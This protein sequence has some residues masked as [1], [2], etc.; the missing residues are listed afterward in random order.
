MK[1]Q[2][3]SSKAIDTRILAIHALDKLIDYIR[4][5]DPELSIGQAT[6]LAAITLHTLPEL[7]QENPL[8]V[9]RFR[10]AAADIKRKKPNVQPPLN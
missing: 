4:S 3:I 2:K 1:K 9:D 7:F 6:L 5:L 8:I 10:E